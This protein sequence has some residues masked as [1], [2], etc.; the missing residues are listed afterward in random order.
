MAEM[1]N[2]PT[3]GRGGAEREYLWS[4][5]VM[6]AS[7]AGGFTEVPSYPCL[8]NSPSDFT[9]TQAVVWHHLCLLHNQCVFSCKLL[10]SPSKQVFGF[11]NLEKGVSWKGYVLVCSDNHHQMPAWGAPLWR[12]G[13]GSPE[14]VVLSQVRQS[15]SLWE[16]I[17]S[18]RICR[19]S[20][21]LGLLDLIVSWRM[22][23]YWTK[24]VGSPVSEGTV[25]SKSFYSITWPTGRPLGG[26]P[27]FFL[28]A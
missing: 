11:Q 15:T 7:A 10:I 14:I 27:Q 22:L 3:G 5:R 12:L 19:T 9:W 20:C 2:V 25:H 26:M 8:W 17:D 21:W 18:A 4:H 24:N 16:R 1:A 23:C 6:K 13:N 28:G